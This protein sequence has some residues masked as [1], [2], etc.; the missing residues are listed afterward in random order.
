[1]LFRSLV[2]FTDRSISDTFAALICHGA[3]DR[4]PE[5]QLVSI[6]NGG[7]WVPELF[8]HLTTAHG[9]MPFA[10]PSHP[11]ERFLTSV[12]VSPY[13]EDD[14]PLLKDLLGVDRLLFGSDFPHAEGLPEPLNFVDEL[15]GFSDNEVRKVMRDNAYRLVGAN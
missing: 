4:F 5:L 3:L 12:W 8:R 7:M 9:K 14:M 2:A 15:E 1:M 10:F 13:F 6:E 11:V